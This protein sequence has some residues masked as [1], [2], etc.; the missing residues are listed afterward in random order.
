MPP[1]PV[2]LVICEFIEIGSGP[3]RGLCKTA[4]LS[5]SSVPL[6]RLFFEKSSLVRFLS[7]DIF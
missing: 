5:N 7:L 6:I 4:V 1:M 2:F 3:G